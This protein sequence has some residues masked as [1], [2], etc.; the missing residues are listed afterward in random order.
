MVLLS[1]NAWS[2]IAIGLTLAFVWS[3]YCKM[4]ELNNKGNNLNE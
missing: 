2:V 3:A 1:I 4:R